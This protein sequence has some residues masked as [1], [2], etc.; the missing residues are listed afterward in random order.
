MKGA[1]HVPLEAILLISASTLCFALLDAVMKALSAYY[2][3]LLLV[4]VRWLIQAIALVLWL[5]PRS[6]GTFLRTEHLGKNLLRGAILMGSSICFMSALKYLPLAEATAL[7]YSTPVLVTLMAAIFLNEKMTGPRILFVL[8][9]I[10]GMVLIVRPGT[11][12]F[13]GTALLAIAS[14]AFYATFQI[15]TRRMSDENP[16][17]LLFYPALV[18]V[19]AV[20]AALPF[21]LDGPM[22]MAWPDLALLVGG[23]VMGTFGHFLFILAFKRGDASALTPFT[24]FQLIWAT[25]IGWVVFANFPDP[26]AFIGMAVIAC[27][28]LAIA[29]HE[30]WRARAAATEPA[31]SD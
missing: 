14:A 9:G 25:L 26:P 2:P 13:Q 11:S 5:A 31:N 20:G 15:L 6:G 16:G 29:L 24:Y 30:R 18:C 17:V 4:W 23:G 8:A 3:V 7:N 22:S 10:F 27:S 19:V 12:M 21:T 1:A 28:G